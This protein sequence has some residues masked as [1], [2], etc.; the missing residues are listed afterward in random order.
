MN[1]RLSGHISRFLSTLAFLGIGVLNAQVP[2]SAAYY[3]VVADVQ[4]YDFALRLND[5]TN[6]IEGVA[7]VQVHFAVPLAYW[8]LDLRGPGPLDSGMR[9]SSVSEDGKPVSYGQD[10]NRLYV[11]VHT[12]KNELHV[13]TI[14]Y[15]GTPRDGL[16]ISSN[17]FGKRTFFGDNWPNRAHQWLPC[18][19]LPYDKASL[20]FYVTAPDKYQV[21]SNGRKLSEDSLAGNLKLT[22]WSE[23]QPLPTKVM[24]IGVAEFAIDHPGDVGNIPLFSYVFPQNKERGFSDYAGALQILP[25]YIRMIGPFAYEKLANIQSKTIFGGMENA[26]AIF[27]FENS[28]GYPNVEPLMAHEIAHQWFGDAISEKDFSHLWLSEGFATYM[29]LLYLENK[30]GRDA[31]NKGLSRDRIS[32]ISFSKKRHTPVVDTTSQYM[33]VLNIFSYQKGSW[34]LHML[35]RHLGDSLFWKGIRQY[36]ACY[37]GQNADTKDFRDIMEKVSGEDLSVYFKQWLYTPGIPELRITWAYDTAHKVVE[38]HILQA[39]KKTFA[40]PLEYA[41][42]N[43]SR[44][45]RVNIHRKQTILYRYYKH[46]PGQLQVDPGVNLLADLQVR[47]VTKW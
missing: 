15:A 38:I 17:R 27:Y 26:S 40:F 19:D 6:R 44:V 41:L 18:V 9:V 30:Y 16:I 37:G 35:R 22:H 47:Q 46:K 32:V 29:T 21:V 12:A 10:T 45:Y 24:V 1:R 28:V 34:V 11:E 42:G 36:Y 20:D 14:A 3:R 2:D 7:K 23:S 39:Q 5:S 43:S 31:L 33:E 4:H 13:Y 8:R 25:F